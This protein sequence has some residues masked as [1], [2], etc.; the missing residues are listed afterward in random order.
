MDMLEFRH[1]KPQGI[2]RVTKYSEAHLPTHFGDFRV[3]VFHNDRDDKEHLALVSGDIT[4]SRGILVRVHS[5][6]LTGESLASLRCDCADQLHESMRMISK[7]GRGIIIYLRQEGRGIGLGN[8]VRAYDLQDNG[9]D[10]IDANHQLGFGADERKY[11]MAVAILKYFNIK[12]LLLIT[13]N[14]EK[15][16]DLKEHGIEI[17]QR[18]PIEIEP[19]EYSRDYLRT[20]R[21]KA[22]HLLNHVNLDS[23]NVKL[24]DLPVSTPDNDKK[25]RG[26]EGIS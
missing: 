3:I 18:V 12:S 4:D 23:M 15:I 20:K 13:N 7:A 10:T 26:D 21:D 14:P 16:K 8:K 22:G 24:V 17:I 1:K 11:E 19:N 2:P 5:E 25:D 6:C 9:M